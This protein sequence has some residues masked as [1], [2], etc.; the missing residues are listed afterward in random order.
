MKHILVIDDNV[1]IC[2]ALELLL[3]LNGLKV[4]SVT[5]VKQ[6][7]L[8]LQR[9]S[10]DLIIQDMNFST[11]CVSGDEGKQLFSHLR[12]YYPTIPVIIMTAWASV[13]MAVELV[14]NGAFDY[15]EKPWNDEHLVSKILAVLATQKASGVQQQTADF[16]Y[17]SEVTERLLNKAK[18]VAGADINVLVTGPNGAGKE[19]LADVIHKHS[20]RADKPLVK[21]NMGAIP[22]ELMEAELFGS[23]AGAFTGAKA[24][25][26]RF[27]AADGGTL[28][29]D[30]IGN[31][32]LSGQMK[33]LRVLQSGEFEKV[34]S[35]HTECVNVRVISAT[36]AN[37]ID[38]IKTDTFREDLY[39]RLNVIELCLPP[40]A[41]R[42]ADIEPLALH[43]LKANGYPHD[44]LAH[45]ILDALTQY[46]W[47]GN[48]R[49]LEN[50]CKRAA[51]F[52][53]LELSIDDFGLRQM[54]HLSQAVDKP[55]DRFSLLEVLTN[56]QWNIAKV[57]SELGLS[58]QAVYRRMEKF[59]I[60]K[61]E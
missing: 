12:T 13:K 35:D 53:E 15:L 46:S 50:A 59:D 47:P 60:A 37:L 55:V 49:E 14:K 2:L 41:S 28:L 26:G 57:A 9:Q 51:L 24:R 6:A 56:N 30:E 33:L 38:G 7:E 25:D 36:N 8:M 42:V 43:F 61:P 44:Y 4:T 10:V 39:Y 27:K 3:E 45:E 17:N 18:K 11:G 48:V 32:S 58:R 5:S 1:D 34:G 20:Q 16:I 23:V 52:A 19:R 54:E 21:V 29:L 31:L 40:L 22:Q